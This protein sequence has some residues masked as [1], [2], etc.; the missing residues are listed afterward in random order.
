MFFCIQVDVDEVR[1]WIAN[2]IIMMTMNDYEFDDGD[3]VD[4]ETQFP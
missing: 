4:D 1:L 2:Q 3:Y